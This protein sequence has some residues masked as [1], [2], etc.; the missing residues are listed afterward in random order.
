[1]FTLQ[2]MQFD[3]D[4]G[5]QPYRSF[6]FAQVI[7]LKLLS[8]DSDQLLWPA[9]DCHLKDLTWSWFD[10]YYVHVCCAFLQLEDYIRIENI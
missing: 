4:L 1:M 8:P 9:N 10:T 7:S 5:D 6:S 3:P 2:L